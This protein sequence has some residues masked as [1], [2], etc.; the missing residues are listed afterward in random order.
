MA[1]RLRL[2]APPEAD[3]SAIEDEK[4]VLPTQE[5]DPS[6]EQ[7][8]SDG[9]NPYSAQFDRIDA[10]LPPTP[11][12]SLPNKLEKIADF[13]EDYDPSTPLAEGEMPPLYNSRH[14]LIAHM[15][16]AGLETNIIAS[17]LNVTLPWAS[18]VRNLPAT[19]IRTQYLQAKL[20]NKN[21]KARFQRSIGTSLDVLEGVIAK[22]SREKTRDKIDVA[23]FLLEKTTGKAPAVIEVKGELL[24]SV[25]DR[26]DGMRE[27]GPAKRE[28]SSERE[29]SPEEQATDA[30]DSWVSANLDDL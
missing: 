27:V 25:L 26:L 8:D 21:H 6:E 15:A 30:I 29:Q 3:L 24:V 14:E 23:K 9:R 11:K 22:D 7:E 12:E 10:G 5:P 19:I 17:E 4:N 13:P 28:A 18:H 20:W 2:R 16:A 1:R